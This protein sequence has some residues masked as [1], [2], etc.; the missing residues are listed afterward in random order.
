VAIRNNKKFIKKVALLEFFHNFFFTFF[1][2]TFYKHNEFAFGFQFFSAQCSFFEKL[3]II[4]A[5][6]TRYEVLKYQK[7]L[8][9]KFQIAHFNLDDP[10][11]KYDKTE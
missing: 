1:G 3:F 5:P 4:A 2:I 8:R 10:I 11:L 7:S 9:K 6:N